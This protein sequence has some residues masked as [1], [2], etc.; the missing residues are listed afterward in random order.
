MFEGGRGRLASWAV[1]RRL[2]GAM[3]SGADGQDRGV[4]LFCGIGRLRS[5]KDRTGG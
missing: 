1:A 4:G 5:Q 2:R 3:A